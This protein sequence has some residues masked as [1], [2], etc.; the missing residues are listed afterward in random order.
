M[1]RFN[2]TLYN[3]EFMVFNVPSGGYEWRETDT[4]IVMSLDSNGL[5]LK[6]NDLIWNAGENIVRNLNN[7]TYDA[8]VSHFFA[9]GGSL[10]FQIRNGSVRLD[11]GGDYRSDGP[12]E[13]GFKVTDDT[14]STGSE[15]TMQ[16][17]ISTL[18]SPVDAVLDI[19]FGSGDGCM[20]LSGANAAN[21]KLHVKSNGNW[22]HANLV[23]S[24]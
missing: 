9:I 14:F 2:K 20:G 3:D 23:N 15:G 24:T 22:S 18:V 1:L 10:E 8:G 21:P 11:G 12:T 19:L 7:L 5:D 17:P 4:T 16:I 6:N 13:I